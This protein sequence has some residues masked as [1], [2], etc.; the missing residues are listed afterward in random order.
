MLNTAS[1]ALL[2]A[3]V[4][5]AMVDARA[6]FE[7]RLKAALAK[8]F[9]GRAPTEELFTLSEDSEAAAVIADWQNKADTILTT[10]HEVAKYYLVAPVSGEAKDIGATEPG[11]PDGAT[12]N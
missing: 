2:L 3:A 7:E 10:L 4:V 11:A 5:S 8:D 9:S 1:A 12:L 6:E